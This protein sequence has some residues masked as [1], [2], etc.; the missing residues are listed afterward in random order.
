MASFERAIPI[1]LQ[2][3]GGFVDHPADPGGTT[4]W[5]ISL[6]FIRDFPAFGDID[7][8]GDV[9]PEDI[10][11]MSREQ[12]VKIYKEFWWDKYRYGRFLDQTIATKVFDLSVNMGAPRAHKLLQRAANNAFGLRLTVDGILGNASVSAVNVITDGDQEQQLLT[13]YANEAW[14]FYQRLMNSRPQLR[15]FER[16]WRNRAFSLTKA[17][18]V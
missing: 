4:N 11:N 8:D 6:R 7:L 18:S 16:G 2:H 3:E 5:G 1:I 17:N 9:D 13:A 12:A 15:V 10:R 14:G